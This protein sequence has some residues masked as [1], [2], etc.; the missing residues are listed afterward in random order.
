M[1]LTPG[2]YNCQVTAPSNGWFGEAGDKA[3]PFIRIPLVVMDGRFE[4]EEVTYQ[5]WI[6]DSA[7]QR[8]LKNLREV[9]EWNGDL[10]ELARLSN[11]G[12]FVGQECSIVVEEEEYKGKKRNVIKWLNGPNGGDT[13]MD[14]NKALQ[15][16]AKLTGSQAPSERPP[17]RPR[18]G[19][20][21]PAPTGRP[22]PK[23][24]DLD[25]PEDDIPF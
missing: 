3:T 24:P 25:A 11:N 6:S 5:A 19:Y 20:G 8:T 16:A 23:D 15:L 1:N 22:A 7:A 17:T 12:P 21:Q 14:V 18:A 9:F 10:A 13:M 2:R 4:N